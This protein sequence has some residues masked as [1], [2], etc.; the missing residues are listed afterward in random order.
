MLQACS[1]PGCSE[2]VL[3]GKCP[4]HR[5]EANQRRGSA[6]QRGYDSQWRRLRLRFLRERCE[7]CDDTP[8]GNCEQCHGTGL[9]NRF[10]RDCFQAGFLELAT[11]CHHVESIKRSPHRRLDP[12][13]LIGLCGK[14]HDRRTRQEAREGIGGENPLES[15]ASETCPG[16]SPSGLAFRD[17]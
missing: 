5:R 1:E 15:K 10:C 6:A 14:C 4:A 3:A 2:R 7:A 11:E 8:N 13:N 17:S 16:V 9:A 12:T